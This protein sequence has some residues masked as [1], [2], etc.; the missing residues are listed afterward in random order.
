[1]G[2]IIQMDPL[3]MEFWAIAF[4]WIYLLLLPYLRWSPGAL[5]TPRTKPRLQGTPD[6]LQLGRGWKS[7]DTAAP[8]PG[9]AECLKMSLRSSAAPPPH[10]LLM[11]S[12]RSDLI[13]APYPVSSVVTCVITCVITCP[14]QEVTM[15][16]NST[17]RFT[18]TL[19][20][21]A[22]LRQSGVGQT[23]A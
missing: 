18:P 19:T 5:L 1:M 14:L 8:Q 4:I 13:A 17:C 12:S 16:A 23:A 6:F 15:S 22:C 7:L 2:P 10:T 21:L 9:R 20:S 11:F 3:F